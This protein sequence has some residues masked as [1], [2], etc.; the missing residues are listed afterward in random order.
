MAVV[1]LDGAG[2]STQVRMLG[3]WLRSQGVPG[4]AHRSLTMAPVRKALNAIAEQEGLTDHLELIGGAAPAAGAA[5]PPV[6]RAAR[7]KPMMV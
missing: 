7:S 4:Q 6:T 1:G 3:D 5:R 2:K